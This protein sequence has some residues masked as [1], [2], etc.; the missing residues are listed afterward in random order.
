[1]SRIIF[2]D[3]DGTLLRDDKTVSEKDAEAIRAMTAAGHSF[4]IATGRPFDS[5]IRISDA[6]GL[7]TAGCYMVSY[8]GGHVY[9]CCR[10]EV[11]Y[12]SRLPMQTVRELFSRADA[13]GLYV[14]TYQNGE[15]LTKSE[16]SELSWYASRTN[17]TPRPCGDVFAHLT[18]EPY[19]AIVIHLDDHERLERFRQE[20]ESWA[21]GKCRMIFSSPQYLEVVPVGISKQK[22]IRFLSERLGVSAADTIAVGDETNDIE[23]IKEA[24]V[25]VAVSNANPA[26]KRIA[27]YVTEAGNNESAIAEVIRREGLLQP[28]QSV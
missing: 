4:V 18:D 10:R 3:L 5:A 2:S 8:N 24:G 1:M 21:E 13:A 11:L 7:N 14:H 22:G 19:K 25:G 27:D 17:L 9:D 6:L 20:Q 16:A 28:Q 23:M 26:V 12:G 15:I